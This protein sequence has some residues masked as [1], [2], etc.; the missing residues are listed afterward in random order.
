MKTNHLYVLAFVTSWLLTGCSLDVNLLGAKSSQASIGVN[1]GPTTTLPMGNFT[2]ALNKSI[3]KNKWVELTSNLYDAKG[4]MIDNAQNST[5]MTSGAL[6]TY[7]VNGNQIRKVSLD[8][9]VYMNWSNTRPPMTRDSAGNIYLVS[10]LNGNA[11]YDQGLL[12]ISP[13]GTV[14]KVDLAPE[15]PNGAVD[16]AVVTVNGVEEL[17][18]TP[19]V[20]G[21]PSSVKVFDLNGVYKAGRDYTV[22]GLQVYSIAQHPTT[23]KIYV[24]TNQ[25]GKVSV[26]LQD[27]TPDTPAEI[28][29]SADLPGIGELNFDASG[30]LYLTSY[31]DSWYAWFLNYGVNVYDISAATPTLVRTLRTYADNTN[32]SQV[33]VSPDGSSIMAI[34]YD[35]PNDTYDVL[36]TLSGSTYVFSKLLSSRGSGSADFNAK[37]NFGT[38][39]LDKEENLYVTDAGNKR[40]KVYSM[41]GTLKSSFS[42]DKAGITNWTEFFVAMSSDQKLVTGGYD[43][44]TWASSSA[45]IYIQIRDQTGAELSSAMIDLPS[46]SWMPKYIGI[47]S[48]DHLWF[49]DGQTYFIADLTGAVTSIPYSA[50]PPAGPA[51]ILFGQ[52]SGNTLYFLNNDYTLWGMDT[53]THTATQLM[54]SAQFTAGGI[55]TVLPAASMQ[56]I[57]GG[58]LVFVALDSGMTERLFV[59]VDPAS[60]YSVVSKLTSADQSAFTNSMIWTSAGLWSKGTFDRYFL[61]DLH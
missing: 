17:H 4:G 43:W 3:G 22:A 13:S 37:G 60:H 23:F 2:L 1:D 53:V 36:Y 16:A 26:F 18:V 38:F 50:S 19:W 52:V 40:V 55:F 48:D 59:V 28:D 46:V 49:D 39:A 5:F 42:V 6:V 33:A 61:W 44:Q 58:K 54:G 45:K 51:A 31:E 57:S 15:V 35:D 24:T 10:R 32:I 41:T 56:A 29:F 34:N 20:N 27:G 30:R 21:S 12:V 47:D 9:S 11:A 14:T 7:D 25:P 8:T